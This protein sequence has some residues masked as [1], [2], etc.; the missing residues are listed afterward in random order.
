MNAFERLGIEVKLTVSDDEIR[1][2][3]RKIASGAHPDSGGA[4][5]DFAAIQ[6]AQEVLLSP[7]KRL[8]E[9]LAAKGET[10]DP[11]GQIESALMDLFQKVA[12]VGAVAEAA[13]KALGTA[14]TALA[15]GMAEVAAMGAREKVSALLAEIDDAMRLRIEGFAAIDDSENFQAAAKS[16]RDLVFLEKWRGT[17]KGLYGRLI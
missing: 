8:K 14:Q 7:S 1:D 2:A 9:W 10:V 11:R 13:V 4:E 6:A 17:L 5:E 12:E 3:F 16:M 15:K